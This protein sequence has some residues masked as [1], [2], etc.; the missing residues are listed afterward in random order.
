M[1]VL[2]YVR[3]ENIQKQKKEGKGGMVKGGA[4][5]GRGGVGVLKAKG[6]TH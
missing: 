4:W 1:S 3:K 5:G 2:A 6:G